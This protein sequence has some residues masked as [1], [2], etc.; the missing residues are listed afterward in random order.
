M[1]S[2][3]SIQFKAAFLTLVFLLNTVVGFACAVG[4]NMG[5][6]NGHHQEQGRVH[7]SGHTRKHNQAHDHSK[8]SHDKST[9]TDHASKSQ[10][11]NCCKEQVDKLTKADKLTQPGFNYNLLS[12][13][14]FLLPSAVYR[15][16]E[17]VTFPV[18]VPNTYFVRHCRPPITDVRI[19]IQSFQI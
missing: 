11:D 18:N 3:S 16:G 8:H 14:F 10:K 9:G 13:S 17:E 15:I 4:T 5:F 12:S 1:K 7:S 19:A 6:N 2:R